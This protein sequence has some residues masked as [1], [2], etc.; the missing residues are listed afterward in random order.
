MVAFSE[1]EW[2]W[3]RTSKRNWT[4]ILRPCGI[5]G[6]ATCICTL[7]TGSYGS[8]LPYSEECYLWTWRRPWNATRGGIHVD[9]LGSLDGKKKKRKS[10]YVSTIL[11]FFNLSFTIFNRYYRLCWRDRHTLGMVAELLW[12]KCRPG[13]FPAARYNFWIQKY[14]RIDEYV[15]WGRPGHGEGFAMPRT[16]ASIHWRYEMRLLKPSISLTL[17]SCCWS[18]CPGD[19]PRCGAERKR[20]KSACREISDAGPHGG[21]LRVSIEV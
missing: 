12:G 13:C 15:Y 6:K 4:Y 14:R 17:P 19:H 16:A 5:Q 8:D 7:T 20:T 11:P 10:G 2:T 1:S 18:F 9:T 3:H 21:F